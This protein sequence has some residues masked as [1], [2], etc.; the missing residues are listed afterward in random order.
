[1]A[2]LNVQPKAANTQATPKP[3]TEITASMD[4]AA[5][6]AEKALIIIC[7]EHSDAVVA[8]AQWFKAH[9]LKAG[10]KRLAKLITARV[11]VNGK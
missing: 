9:Y 11:K 1:M 7:N 3:A 6:E 4:A 2:K 5:K 8:I 10:Y